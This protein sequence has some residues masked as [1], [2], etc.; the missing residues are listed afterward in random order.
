MK[1]P[2][3]RAFVRA[4]RENANKP[5]ALI[6][7]KLAYLKSD[8]TFEDMLD[9]VVSQHVHRVYVVDEESRPIAV[10][11]L[12]DVLYAMAGEAPTGRP[13]PQA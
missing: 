2:E 4:S 13:M 8:A 11:T 5:G 7:Q 1:D 9:L 6:G 3:I 10:A 12:T